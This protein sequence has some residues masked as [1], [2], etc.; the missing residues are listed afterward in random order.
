MEKEVRCICAD[1]PADIKREGIPLRFPRQDHFAEVRIRQHWSLF[2]VQMLQVLFVF[3]GS[4]VCFGLLV[5]AYALIDPGQPGDSCV[6]VL[7]LSKC[8]LLHS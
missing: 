6:D 3:A 2:C 4:A 1:I 5:N 7:Q 8:F